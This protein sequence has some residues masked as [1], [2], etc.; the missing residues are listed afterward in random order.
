MLRDPVD[1]TGIAANRRIKVSIIINRLN[2]AGDV[3]FMSFGVAIGIAHTTRTPV[4]RCRQVFP[5]GAFGWIIVIA[6]NVPT[7]VNGIG[8]LI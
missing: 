3:P 5:S 4:P 2:C 1:I 8:M 7:V 6:E